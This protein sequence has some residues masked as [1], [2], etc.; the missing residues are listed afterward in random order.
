MSE[1]FSPIKVQNVL[2]SL[3]VYWWWAKIWHC[4]WW[5]E[6]TMK[7]ARTSWVLLQTQ[8]YFLHYHAVYDFQER[9][10]VKYAQVF[11]YWY[12]TFLLELFNYFE[13][14]ACLFCLI[15]LR[16]SQGNR[17]R[18]RITCKK[19]NCNVFNVCA[20]KIFECSDFKLNLFLISIFDCQERHKVK[21][22]S[23]LTDDSN[24]SSFKL[25]LWIKM[26]LKFAS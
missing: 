1:K 21:R 26:N 5:Y 18:F 13:I 6:Q 12:E 20:D 8:V 17:P 9:L 25:S 4:L 23:L 22:S 15:E 19:K 3:T 10:K 14:L 24:D 7:I 16:F 2:E 11:D